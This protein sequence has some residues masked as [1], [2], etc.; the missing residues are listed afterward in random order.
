VAAAA[1]SAASPH[2]LNKASFN[3]YLQS[4][5]PLV[6]LR[7]GGSDPR[8]NAS[9]PGSVD[10]QSVAISFDN[11]LE[12]SVYQTV[13][14]SLNVG[15]CVQNEAVAKAVAEGMSVWVGGG[16]GEARTGGEMAVMM[17][18]DEDMGEEQECAGQADAG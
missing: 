3:N 12:T 18:I 6:N 13:E 17:E 9:G 5:I 10:V 15:V 7:G 2:F 1:V 11:R 8:M 16:W 4:T 14:N